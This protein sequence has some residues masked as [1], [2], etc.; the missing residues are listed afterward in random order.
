MSDSKSKYVLPTTP[1]SDFSLFP[2]AFTST[3]IAELDKL[4]QAASSVEPLGLVVRI[5]D[6][7]E[8]PDVLISFADDLATAVPMRGAPI[9][10]HPRFTRRPSG[11]LP[12]DTPSAA[13]AKI[14]Q[15]LQGWKATAHAYLV[16]GA[17]ILG[18]T[19]PVGP[20]T[21]TVLV[22]DDISGL[23]SSERI[24]ETVTHALRLLGSLDQQAQG[25]VDIRAGG[26]HLVDARAA[27]KHVIYLDSLSFGPQ[28]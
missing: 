20:L 25:D 1:V 5:N 8:E 23:G 18:S 19:Y 4:G 6:D 9:D 15:F 27:G 24:G 17:P 10:G 28:E 16:Y 26:A 2:E 21:G 13:A 12:T 22:I 11:I 14:I 7:I 3:L